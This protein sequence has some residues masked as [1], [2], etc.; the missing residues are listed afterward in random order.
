[1]FDR[2]ERYDYQH[3]TNCHLIF[4]H[5][6]PSVEEIAAFYP[7]SY[8]VYREHSRQKEI[9]QF[10]KSILKRYYGYSHLKTSRL[11]DLACRVITKSN[12]D[13]RIPFIP[14]GSLLDVGCGNGRFLDGMKK[15][16]WKVKGVEFNEHAVGMCKLSGLDVHHGD[17][18]SA[19][20]EPDSF[21]IINVSHV[22]EHV[23]HPRQ[24][25]SELAKVLKPG[26]TLIIKTPN[27]NAFGRKLFNTNWFPDDIPRHIYLYSEKNLRQIGDLCDLH[28]KAIKT[29]S[30]LKVVLNSIDY[31]LENKGTP[32]KRIKWRRVL[33]NVFSLVAKHKNQGDEIFA[34]F[35][36]TK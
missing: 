1:M 18:L 9:S 13:Y 35:T 25:F 28:L 11:N 22:I 34:V 23:P 29:R 5:P 33:A 4:Q 14:G 8:D 19:H 21:D 10:A 15:L 6:A 7:N 36:K 32:S 16:G 3:C 30:S 24:L 27:S 20:F 26:G 31:V 12:S 17:L 2:Y